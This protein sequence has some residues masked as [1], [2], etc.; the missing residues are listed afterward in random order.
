[1]PRSQTFRVGGIGTY[2]VVVAATARSALGSLCAAVTTPSPS[3]GRDNVVSNDL[4]TSAP[5]RTVAVIVEGGR[6]CSDGTRKWRYG[7][8]GSSS[9][10]CL[11]DL[12]TS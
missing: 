11:G 12:T 5:D 1:V 9:T 4:T 7:V 3:I 8:G 10:R 2:R 6:P